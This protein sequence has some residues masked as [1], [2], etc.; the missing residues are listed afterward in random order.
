MPEQFQETLRLAAILGREFDY[1]T[2]AK[3][4]EVSEDALIETLEAAEHAQLIEEVSGKGGVTFSF[5]HA[6]IPA[7][8]EES[9]H[10]LRR[11]K[12]HRQAAAAIESLRPEDHEALAYHYGEAG[13]DAKALSYYTQA[14]EAAAR[15]YANREAES[16]FR[17]A[18]N[19]AQTDADKAHLLSQLGSSVSNQGRFDEAIEV[20][21]SAIAHYKPLAN[22]DRMAWCYARAA[23]AA[24][25][26]GDFPRGLQL[27]E[28]GMQAV[29]GAPA[30]ADL[31]DLL[32][33]TARAYHFNGVKD[34]AASLTQRSLEMAEQ[35]S[36]V[37]VQAESLITY[38]VLDGVPGDEAIA[39]LERAV[40][41]ARV[42][43]LP[44]TESRAR[45]NLSVTL[46][47]FKG[48]V[49]AA[50]KHLQEAAAVARRLGQAAMELFYRSGDV[51]WA[52]SQGALA[53]AEAEL[54]GLRELYE[55]ASRPRNSGIVFHRLNGNLARDRGNL[56]EAAELYRENLAQARAGNQLQD[57]WFTG[58]QLA[59]V[60]T[61]MGQLAEAEEILLEFIEIGDKIGGQA[62]PRCLISIVYAKRGQLESAQ[63]R[64]AEAEAEENKNPAAFGAAW[65][66]YSM[67]HLQQAEANW[68]ETWA[69]FERCAS[70]WERMGMRPDRCR[71]LRDWAKAHLSRGEP[72]DL[73]RARQLLQETLT[74]FEAMGSPGYVKSIQAELASL[75]K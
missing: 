64:F 75:A 39:A 67:A 69:A 48:E 19:L 65:L 40:E 8:L 15:A 66:A 13:D 50:R 45:N 9:V 61:E 1:D 52:I 72:E 12:L 29:E 44:E 63:T 20:W 33:E 26:A 34:K 2:L 32:H 10:T 60:L 24:W 70:Q 23:R 28:E 11:R 18:S 47:I 71:V 57:I 68:N 16:H 38:G 21:K 56:S 46:G 27:A 30:S 3:A 4:S 7:T 22:L 41:L 35:T 62:L 55:Q 58:C 5:L 42:H 25:E 31:A 43:N 14:G 53:Y 51:G 49:Q 59:D 74:E 6:L 17:A 54:P 73:E 36:A 37:K